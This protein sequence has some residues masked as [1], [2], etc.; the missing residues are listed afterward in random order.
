MIAWA[1]RIESHT[2]QP[3]M[4]TRKTQEVYAEQIKL[5]RPVV[6]RLDPIG[7]FRNKFLSEMFDLP[8]LV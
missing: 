6:M 3:I 8:Y 7:L 5:I 2:F 1:G 4:R